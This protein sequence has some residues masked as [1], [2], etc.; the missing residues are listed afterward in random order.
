MLFLPFLLDDRRIRI[1]KAKKHMDPTDPDPD[2][3]HWLQGKFVAILLTAAASQEARPRDQVRVVAKLVVRGWI[4]RGRGARRC[5]VPRRFPTGRV[6]A[7][8]TATAQV[9]RFG[10]FCMNK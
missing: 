6:A 4:G 3:Q 10:N 1:R 7:A 9:Q 8:A 2:L 5:F